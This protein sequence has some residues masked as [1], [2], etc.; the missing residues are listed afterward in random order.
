MLF[1]IPVKIQ[2]LEDVILA[3][4]IKAIDR[5]MMQKAWM[6]QTWKC[7][8]QRKIRTMPLILPKTDSTSI[9]HLVRN[10]GLEECRDMRNAFPETHTSR[11]RTN[12]SIPAII[13]KTI[14]A[15]K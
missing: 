10:Y 6:I 12:L 2:G 15:S 14:N 13:M 7:H 11:K 8:G 3:F 9:S 1:K 4:C 5:D